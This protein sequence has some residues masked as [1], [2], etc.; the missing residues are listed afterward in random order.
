MHPLWVYVKPTVEMVGVAAVEVMVWH[1]DDG[2][3]DGDDDGG[4]GS[5][6]M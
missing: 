5:V 6:E 3:H 1:G 2:G 4:K